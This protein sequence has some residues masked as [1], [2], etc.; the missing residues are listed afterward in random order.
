MYYVYIIRSKTK[1][2]YYTG[3]SKNV[4][5]RLKSHNKGKV[6]STK[7]FRPW[8]IVCIETFENKSEALKREKQIK[9]YKGG[10]AFKKLIN[11]SRRDA[12]VV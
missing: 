1:G 2:R 8:E 10:N 5:E 12:G 11:N 6:R 3:S 9:S 7:S 4:F